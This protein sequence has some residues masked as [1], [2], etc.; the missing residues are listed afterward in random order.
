MGMAVVVMGIEER[1]LLIVVI[2]LAFVSL[3]HFYINT[4]ILIAGVYRK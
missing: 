2:D 1:F 4:N 3:H